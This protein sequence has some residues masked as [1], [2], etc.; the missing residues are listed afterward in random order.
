MRCATMRPMMSE[1]P[2][3]PNEMTILMVW[4]GYSCAAAG[5]AVL[6]QPAASTQAAAIVI[7]RRFMKFLPAAIWFLEVAPLARILEKNVRRRNMGGE[8]SRPLLSCADAPAEHGFPG[9]QPV[10]KSRQPKTNLRGVRCRRLGAGRSSS[11]RQRRRPRWAAALVGA[12]AVWA[13]AGYPNKPIKFIVPL[14]PG[15]AIDFIAR[16]IGER[17]SALDRPAGRGREPHRRRRHHRHGH[18]D[19]ERSGR[20]HRADHQRQRG[21]RA[22]HR[23]PV[24][25]TTPRNCCRSAI[26]AG[27]RRS[28]PRTRTSASAR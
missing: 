7:S 4:V 28:S 5:C 3:A 12:P 23:E 11:G 15:G 27:R 16:A 8:A 2:P 10:I 6:S 26:S 19:E 13:Q 25:T 21:E 17:M 24:A 22:A 20:L 14:A 18:R 9:M 1:P